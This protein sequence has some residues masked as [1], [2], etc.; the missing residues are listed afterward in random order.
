MY[1]SIKCVHSLNSCCSL[2]YFLNGTLCVHV[3]AKFDHE[4][5][6]RL[7]R[8]VFFI[9]IT[10]NPPDPSQDFAK[11]TPDILMLLS[12]LL[13]CRT[14]LDASLTLYTDLGLSYTF[15]LACLYI[16]QFIKLIMTPFPLQN[17]SDIW[18]N[19]ITSKYSFGGTELVSLREY[20]RYFIVI[21]QCFTL[22]TLYKYKQMLVSLQPHQ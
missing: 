11:F 4:Y 6:F 7:G 15:H 18:M 3:Y 2:F 21:M 16:L 12:R 5:T 13:S 14:Y 1:N 20:V 19:Q 9:T 17:V 22:F 10:C 8:N